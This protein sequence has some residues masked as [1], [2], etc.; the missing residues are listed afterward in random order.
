MYMYVCTWM[1]PCM[2]QCFIIRT[3]SYK[4][5]KLAQMCTQLCTFLLPYILQITC[6]FVDISIYMYVCY[7]CISGYM[8]THIRT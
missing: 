1:H 6:T 4:Y 8:N 7:S 3:H 2:N 5:T